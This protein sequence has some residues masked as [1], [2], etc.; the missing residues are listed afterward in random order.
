MLRVTGAALD[1]RG[2]PRA[3]AAASARARAAI[4]EARTTGPMR[5]RQ[6]NMVD[7]GRTAGRIPPRWLGDVR[8]RRCGV[9]H[10]T[11]RGRPAKGPARPRRLGRR[12][13]PK[14]KT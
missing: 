3:S 9:A 8:G 5:A 2:P 13:R 1:A 7:E 6:T 10:D 12:A 4:A 11:A 14:T